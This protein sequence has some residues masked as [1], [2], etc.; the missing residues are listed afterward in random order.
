[1]R[2]LPR[3]VLML[4]LL[5]L[6]AA[7]ACAQQS[8]PASSTALALNDF[9][10]PSLPSASSGSS[11]VT[12]PPVAPAAVEGWFFHRFAIGSYSSPLGFG[13]R[14][15]TS[16]APSLNLRAGAS[17]FSL[18]M[19]RTQ[20]DIPYTA[21]VV[22]QSE[23]VMV[24]WYPFHNNFHL[25]PGVLFASS[26]RAFGSASIAAGNSFTL[27]GTTYYS[28][29]ADPVQASGY[30]RF[31]RTAPTL[32]MGWGNWIR[33]E[34]QGHWTFPFEFG[35]AF[36]GDPAT[37]LNFT[38]QVCT[39]Y[40]Q[41]DCSDIASNPEVQANIAAEQKKLQNDADWA[42]FYPILAGGIVYRF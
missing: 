22:L 18:S 21:N 31:R 17:Y 12:R 13:G 32:T 14:I 1:M 39:G 38:G 23:Q 37:A 25:S 8:A 33:R 10:A 42:R 6:C 11:G 9:S 24:D 2:L 41:L 36:E 28:G 19:S 27:N 35:V 26:N 3:Y 15:A 20:D 34:S 30:V 29:A 7:S 5:S 16:I 4:A 40:P